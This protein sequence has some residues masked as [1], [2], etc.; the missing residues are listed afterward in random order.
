MEPRFDCNTLNKVNVTKFKVFTDVSQS[1]MV[2]RFLLGGLRKAVMI[3]EEVVIE[4]GHV[5]GQ[6][7]IQRNPFHS[8]I[9]LHIDEGKIHKLYIVRNPDKL[10]HI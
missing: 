5:N 2:G 6:P 3:G 4:I 1:R 10:G 9:L 7:A 8:V